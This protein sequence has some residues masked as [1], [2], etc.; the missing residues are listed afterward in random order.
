MLCFSVR[1]E[2]VG[3]KENV[4]VITSIIALLF[5][6]GIWCISPMAAVLIVVIIGTAI[7]L[8]YVGIPVAAIGAAS[9]SLVLAGIFV[10]ILLSSIAAFNKGLP[11]LMATSPQDIANPDRGRSAYVPPPAPVVKAKPAVARRAAAAPAKK[12]TVKG[13][14]DAAGKPLPKFLVEYK[15]HNGHK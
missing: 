11:N 9:G 14:C 3:Q 7:I 4:M 10:W 2:T 5:L 1:W 6:A 15:K 8:A 12:C 13:A